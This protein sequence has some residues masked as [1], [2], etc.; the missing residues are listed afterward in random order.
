MY[1]E[2]AFGQKATTLG[3]V[4]SA[5]AG[6][7]RRSPKNSSRVILTRQVSDTFLAGHDLTQPVLFYPISTELTVTLEIQNLIDPTRPD[8]TREI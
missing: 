3:S 2:K 4:G 6:P 7:T 5:G 8:S 1:R